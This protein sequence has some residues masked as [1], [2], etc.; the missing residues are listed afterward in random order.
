MKTMAMLGKSINHWK[1]NF[2]MTLKSLFWVFN[3]STSK[4]TEQIYTIDYNN[5]GLF[6]KHLSIGRYCV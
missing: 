1:R 6:I 5:N 2:I 4:W 3:V